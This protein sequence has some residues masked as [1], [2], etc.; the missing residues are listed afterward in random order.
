MHVQI[1]TFSSNS[2]ISIECLC[3]KQ[4]AGDKVQYAA[5][6]HSLAIPAQLLVYA[7]PVLV[8]KCDPRHKHCKLIDNLWPKVLAHLEQDKGFSYL[9]EVLV[10][11]RS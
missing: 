3:L 6:A 10:S 11:V 4:P 8:A 5:Y 7:V 9:V 1:T 2:H